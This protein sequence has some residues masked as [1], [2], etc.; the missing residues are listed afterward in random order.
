MDRGR[1]V[2]R[3]ALTTGGRDHRPRYHH[4]DGARGGRRRGR[5]PP[6][7]AGALMTWWRPSRRQ[8][9]AARLVPLAEFEDRV[10]RRAGWGCSPWRRALW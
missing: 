2:E 7:G 10:R 8:P 1:F 3:V 5:R 4:S 6:A 9:P